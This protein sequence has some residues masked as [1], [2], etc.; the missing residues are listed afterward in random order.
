MYLRIGSENP[1]FSC[2]RHKWMAP[3]TAG[4]LDIV[5]TVSFLSTQGK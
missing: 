1:C 4:L 2:G 3:N 5:L